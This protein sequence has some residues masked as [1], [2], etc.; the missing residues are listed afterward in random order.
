MTAPTFEAYRDSIGQV[1]VHVS[2]LS[3]TPAAERIQAAAASLA[4]LQ[5][6]DVDTVT[7]WLRRD[8]ARA[9]VLT[10]SVGLTSERTKRNLQ[11]RF[12]SASVTA[13]VRSGAREVVEWL[14]AEFD[15]LA[16]LRSQLDRQYT[17]GDV[18]VAR[19]GSRVRAASA[20][21]Q[22]RSVED[23]IEDIARELGLTIQVRTRFTGRGGRDAPCDLL[24][25]DEDGTEHI[26]VA[27]K[28]FD[29]TGSKLTDAVRE[30]ADMADVR[31]PRQAILAV[32]DGIGWLARQADLRR[33]HQMRA[34][35]Q[36]DGL[37]TI[38]TLETFRSDLARLAWLRGLAV[39]A[40]EDAEGA[41]AAGA[42][43]DADDAGEA[44]GP[45]RPAASGPGPGAG[46]SPAEPGPETMVERPLW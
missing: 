27:A 40:A 6:L 44:V 1:S 30:I 42:A 13:L 36:I 15:L 20:G 9:E 14:D 43:D 4:L 12:G 23:R 34:T 17:F 38:A 3:T 35:D 25:L 39:R 22:G 7:A 16:S 8:P 45:E 18:L 37:Y 41:G 31:L 10:L 21:E 11:A 26:A 24:V 29:S 28:G 33:I 19:A 32:V 46:G 5:E 2:P